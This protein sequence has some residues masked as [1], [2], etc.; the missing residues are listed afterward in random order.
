MARKTFQLFLLLALV[1]LGSCTGG[2]DGPDPYAGLVR[3]MRSYIEGRM[4]AEGVAGLSIAL[5]DNGRIAWAQGFG[6]A[7]VESGAPATPDTIFE[8]GSVSKTFTATLVMEQNERGLMDLDAP[9]AQYLPGFSIN[10][11][12]PDSDPITIRTCMTHHSGIPG[13]IFNNLFATAP[14]PGFA[15]W[16]LDY[17]QGEW[18]SF[19][20][21]YFWSYSNTAV[22]F[23]GQAAA[24]QSGQSLTDMGND[25]LARLGMEHSSFSLDSV[26]PGLLATPY[27][28]NAQAGSFTALPHFVCNAPATGGI[29]SSATDMAKY[30]T[31]V[32]SQGRPVLSPQSMEQMLTPQNLDVPLDNPWLQ[33]LNWFLYDSSLNYAGR[34]AWHAGDTVASHSVVLVLPDLGLGA[35]ALSNTDSGIGLVNDAARKLL[36]LAVEVKTGMTPPD[37]PAPEPSPIVYR[38]RQELS[39]LAG[40]YVLKNS[41][42]WDEIEAADGK[43]IWR[44]LGQAAP[45]ELLPRENGLF[46]EADSQELQLEFLDIS[47]R[48]VMRSVRDGLRA[49]TAQRYDPVPVPPAWAARAGA[50]NLVNLPPTDA[51]RNVPID[52]AISPAQITLAMEGNLLVLDWF[53]EGAVQKFIIEAIDDDRAILFG[54]GR[55]NSSSIRALPGQNGENLVVLGLAYE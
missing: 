24:A 43:L 35:V 46:S 47:G 7:D 39:P 41:L 54:L 42:G 17:V 4:A 9:L 34:V 20:V 55:I 19:P 5:V 38:T 11:S 6:L 27:Y 32:L 48:F 2:S 36:Q 16:M 18:T 10:Q 3:Q 29:Y 22:F 52:L 28:Y 31:M 40:I 13:D 14:D 51:S 50:W 30:I 23:L 33:G 8:I 15:Q 26:D 45:T 25:L 49:V 53:T 44:R 21:N 37:P 1:L 12:F